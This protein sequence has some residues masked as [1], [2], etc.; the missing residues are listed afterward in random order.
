MVIFFII[1]IKPFQ[2][3]PLV[4]SKW[5]IIALGYSA[6]AICSYLLIVPLQ[7]IIF[8][9]KNSWN[10]KYE[11]TLI[12]IFYFLTLIISYLYHK[13]DF[14]NSLYNLQEF[15]S[16]IFLPSLIVVKPLLI[17]AR[18]NLVKMADETKNDIIINGTYKLDYL[19][20]KS[21]NLVCVSSSKN[22]VYVH[23]LDNGSLSKK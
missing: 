18:V 4:N 14:T 13:S 5:I 6:I 15:S 9:K 12:L 7:N 8:T 11:I 21:E 3:E 19:K 10:L 20:I 16:N 22:Y 1:L 23:Y 17:F 2:I